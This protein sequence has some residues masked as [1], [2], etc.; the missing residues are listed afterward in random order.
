MTDETPLAVWIF[1]KVEPVLPPSDEYYMTLSRIKRVRY[2]LRAAI[3]NILCS[4]ESL[5]VH[6]ILSLGTVILF[7]AFIHT[8]DHCY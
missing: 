6:I 8:S 3:M 2:T 5:Q 7:T 1:V 4:E